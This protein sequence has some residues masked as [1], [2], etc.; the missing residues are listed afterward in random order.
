MISG[1]LY[2]LSGLPF[3]AYRPCVNKSV[4]R[5]QRHSQE[6]PKLPHTKFMRRLA[7]AA[8]MFHKGSRY[9][10]FLHVERWPYVHVSWASAEFKA[11]SFPKL[12]KRLHIPHP[13]KKHFSDAFYQSG[14]F[15]QSKR[16]VYRPLNMNFRTNVGFAMMR[17]VDLGRPVSF[18]FQFHFGT[19]PALIS[20]I[21]RNL[22]LKGN[23]ERNSRGDRS[24]E[25]PTAQ[26]QSL[27]RL[28]ENQRRVHLL[29]DEVLLLNATKSIA[30][31][32]PL[33]E[34]V[35]PM[36]HNKAWLY[37]LMNSDGILTVLYY[38]LPQGSSP[39]CRWWESWL[40]YLF[41]E[42]IIFLNATKNLRKRS[43]CMKTCQRSPLM[44]G[45][46]FIWFWTEFSW[47]CIAHRQVLDDCVC[48]CVFVFS[49]ASL[50]VLI[51]CEIVQRCHFIQTHL[52]KQSGAY[53]VHIP[54]L[55]HWHVS[56]MIMQY[57]EMLG[58]SLDTR[59]QKPKA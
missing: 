52:H 35:S 14:A 51:F 27:F 37:F 6:I 12:G 34:N 22:E 44:L 48:V 7:C 36:Y 40:I 9:K 38:W 42:E 2:C 30:K 41:A 32:V 17:P 4:R 59:H 55:A 8:H 10:I 25:L 15:Y 54:L 21:Q 13:P 46:I 11:H 57:V 16:L 47:D 1:A 58:I 20:A 53:P 43:H 31:E 50:L 3:T 33:H 24:S 23:F 45:Y 49:S 19:Y 29:V 39:P 56:L 18:L 5:L 26:C 28:G